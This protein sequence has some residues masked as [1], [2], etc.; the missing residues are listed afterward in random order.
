M[1]QKIFRILL[2]C[3]LLFQAIYTQAEARTWSNREG[4]EIQAELVSYDAE[5]KRVTIKLANGKQSTLLIETLSDSDQGWLKDRQKEIDDAYVKSRE[6]AGKIISYKSA[7][8]FAVGYHV[9]YPKDFSTTSPPA[10]IIMFSPGGNGMD[11]LGSVKEACEALGW[12]GV[13]CDVFRNDTDE[14]V[15][16]ENWLEILPHIEK[17][18]PH[19]KSLLYLGG[20]SGGALRAYDYTEKTV[21]PWKGVLAFG[22]WLGGKE[23]LNCPP[24]M[25]VAI[26]NGDADAN[27]NSQMVSNIPILKKERCKVETFSFPGGHTIAPP[28]TVL[29]AME[30]LKEST[31]PGNR[32]SAGK[33]S[34]ALAD[35][36][37]IK[38]K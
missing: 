29:K 17:T 10:M 26:V 27:A 18:I 25:A 32:M 14:A 36:D 33:R 13:G 31:V 21:R 4:K 6:N 9:Y 15:L 16:D 35:P 20:M 34:P 3:L 24:K 37:L 19:D 22:G 5:A 11:I 30:W 2:P 8:K 1:C 28:D 12:I 38:V 7:G 23:T